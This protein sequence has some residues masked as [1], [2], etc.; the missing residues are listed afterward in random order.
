[1]NTKMSTLTSLALISALALSACGDNTE[2]ADA[3]EE[4][5]TEA[6]ETDDN[7]ADEN[8][9]EG[10]DAEEDAIEPSDRESHEAGGPQ[11]RLVLTYDGGVAVLDGVSTEVIDDF[12]A[13]GFLRV[14]GAG[15]GRHAFLA[16][17][18]SF[19][20]ID[21]GTWGEPHGEHNHYYTTDPLLTDI[22][23]D[24]D[25]PA[26]VVSHD[27]IGT[28]FFDGSGEYHW[29]DLEDLDA[30]SEIETESAETEGAHHGVAVVLEDGSRFETLEDRSGARFLD[31]DGEE[32]ARNEECPGVHGEAAGPD[33]IL[34]VG[35]EDGVLVWDGDD[36]EKLDTGE[37][38]SRIGNLFPSEGS[39]VFLGDYGTDEDGEEPMTE[40]ALVNTDSG[41]IT[42]TSVDSPY[43]WRNLQRG[44][45]GEALV[46]TEDGQ[47]HII[48][49]ETGEHLDHLQ[50][51][52]EW[53]EPEEWQEPRPA[54]RSSGDLVYVT[55]PEAQQIH[56]VDLTEGEVIV[57][58][59]L[60]FVPNEIVVIEGRPV[61]GVS[62]DY[63][64]DDDEHG[65]DEDDHDAEDHDDHD[66][67]HD[68]DEDDHEDHDHDHDDDDHDH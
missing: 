24:G 33:G 35:C 32:V 14:N 21:A 11:P 22:T 17:G 23:V 68:E 26:H 29:F 36:F 16:E 6:V 43:N 12:D 61:E 41:E 1:M 28:L 46:L 2:D 57:T 59:D 54:I 20:L 64:D 60:D 67:G 39:P 53:T 19:R 58:G 3:S 65:D 9:E 30:E 48:D 55:D 15:D 4:A 27:G 47:L 37:E 7:G 50:I 49:E 52:D 51:L 62:D 18:D 13:E 10:D 42:T 31:A 63:D 56:I 40:V 25:T 45:N 5:D 34:A 66:H 44:P 38:Y 8:P